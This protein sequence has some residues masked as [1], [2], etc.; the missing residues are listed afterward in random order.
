[1]HRGVGQAKYRFGVGG[2]EAALLDWNISGADRIL[3][4]S[5]ERPEIDLLL[6][7]AQ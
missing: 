5:Q 4:A 6:A 1:M 7:S 3:G 2:A